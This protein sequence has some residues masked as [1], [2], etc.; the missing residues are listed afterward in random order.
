MDSMI[1]V[2]F[3]DM[4]PFIEEGKIVDVGC[5]TGSL[6]QCL[7]KAFPESDIIG[8][9]AVRRFYEYCKMQDYANP[10]V[11]FYRRNVTDQNFQENSMNT[12][13]YSSVLH[14]VYS[15]IGESTLHTVLKNTYAQLALGGRIIIRDVVGPDN[16][17]QEVYMHL[18][19][20]DGKSEGEIGE[21]STYAKFFHFVKDF[22]PRKIDFQE[23]GITAKK[24]I[25]LSMQD[26]YEY[27]SK[28]TYI[29]NWESEMHEEFGFYSFD[30][31]T[32]ELKNIG[33]SIVEG[34]KPFT[35]QW[36]V[37]NKYRSRVSLFRKD[38]EVLIP[39]GFPATN[40]VLVGEKGAG[41]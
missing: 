17:K 41:V 10:F 5:S 7:A 38:G 9:E 28:M 16:P 2:K 8:I 39:I 24:Y 3:N 36:I 27:I 35:N 14:E 1:D 15:Y 33:F 18:N 30:R 12:F 37:E 20:E 29:D 31:W 25:V 22:K 11:F 13:I 6:I 26:A 40:M 19:A 21:L 23:E 34:S 32:K 4:R